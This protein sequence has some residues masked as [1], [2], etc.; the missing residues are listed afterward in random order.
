MITMI[1]SI[2]RPS[3]FAKVLGVA[4]V[5]ALVF[6]AGRMS[7]QFDTSP[8]S[9]SAIVVS[10]PAENVTTVQVPQAQ[11]TPKIVN[12]S[13]KVVDRTEVNALFTEN[14]KL[15]VKV[16]ELSVSLAQAVSQ[17]T[18]TAVVTVITPEVPAVNDAPVVPAVVRT[19]FNDFRL[20]FIAQGAMVDYTLTQKFSIVNTTGRNEKNVP[21]SLVRL[22]EI[23]PGETR[24]LIPTTETTTVVATGAAAHWYR[25]VGVQ[26]GLGQVIATTG[27]VMPTAFNAELTGVLAVPW[28]KRGS[29]RATETTRWAIATP[30]VVF[31]NTT[32]S[33]GVLPVS[34][35]L[36]TLSPTHNPFTNLWVSPYLGTTSGTQ[37][38]ALGMILSVT[39]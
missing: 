18:G 3:T 24:T 33:I 11:L 16:T 17:G 20:H 8:D 5:L 21:T 2:E 12:E 13:V 34:L 36:G 4:V 30:A 29:H 31:S 26:G 32:T 7:N 37:V 15:N 25:K 38:N 27:F 9:P 23:G 39:F 6:L 1:P 19:E 35:N 28:L 10:H 22:Y 14:A